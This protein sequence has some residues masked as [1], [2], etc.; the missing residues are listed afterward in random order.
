MNA[1]QRIETGKFEQKSSAGGIEEMRR[2]TVVDT[3]QAK[4][5]GGMILWEYLIS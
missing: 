5:N 2:G 4:R 1:A 3:F